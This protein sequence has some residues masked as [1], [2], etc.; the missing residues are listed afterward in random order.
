MLQLRYNI[1]DNTAGGTDSQNAQSTRS[2]TLK[3]SVDELWWT[4]AYDTRK[5]ARASFNNL[6]VSSTFRPSRLRMRRSLFHSTLLQFELASHAATL[7]GDVL[8]SVTH[9]SSYFG[10]PRSRVDV[11]QMW[12]FLPQEIIKFVDYVVKHS[13]RQAWERSRSERKTSSVVHVCTI[14]TVVA[15]LW[16]DSKDVRVE[17]VLIDALMSS[18]WT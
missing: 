13:W 16:W 11:S 15:V 18:V 3:E 12:R 4:I 10:K 5:N 6:W 1:L 8:R 2:P 14:N 9:R 17:W 7:E